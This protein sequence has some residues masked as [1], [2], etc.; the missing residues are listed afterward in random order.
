M[1]LKEALKKV[2]KTKEFKDWKKT[3]PESYF[4]FAFIMLEQNE[5]PWQV[6]YCTKSTERVTTFI[7]SEPVEVKADE[8]VFKEPEEKILE[9]NTEKLILP[10]KKIIENA[11]S[12]IKKEYPREMLTKKIV[13]LQNIKDIGTI[14]NITS[15]SASFNTIN[16]KID[17]K[18]GS[19][20]NHKLE[21]IMGM[22]KK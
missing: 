20:I 15:I 2:E 12:F 18:D 10:F 5:T 19:V 14:W 21:S 4:S 3:N 8:E 13:I 17:P 16:L 11:D 9:I 7:L 22:I 1:E 6:G